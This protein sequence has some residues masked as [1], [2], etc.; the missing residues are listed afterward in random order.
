MK[1]GTSYF[2]NINAAAMYYRSA[3]H[4]TYDEAVIIAREKIENGEI[5][6]GKPP[7]KSGDKLFIR[8]HRYFIEENHA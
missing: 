5:S 8:D 2:P 6:I 4:T 1:I 7:V 3:Q